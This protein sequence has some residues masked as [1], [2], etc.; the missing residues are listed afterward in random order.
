M[1]ERD[2]DVAAAQQPGQRPLDLP[3]MATQ[4]GVGLH[5]TAGD[6]RRDPAPAQQL[7]ATRVVLSFVAMQLGWPLARSTRPTAWPDHRQHRIDQ[8]FQQL[9]I[10]G[11]GG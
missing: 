7:S 1:Q 9:G 5:P 4:P 2:Q 6:P 11:V 10:M 3:T 8:L